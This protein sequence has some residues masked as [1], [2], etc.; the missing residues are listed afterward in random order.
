LLN[1]EESPDLA[2]SLCKKL[3]LSTNFSTSEYAIPLYQRCVRSFPNLLDDLYVIASD[4]PRQ[5]GQLMAFLKTLGSP[6]P[7]VMGQLS[8]ELKKMK[9]QMDIGMDI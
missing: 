9:L 7:E 1:Q 4:Y 8:P 2:V 5:N 6:S 3:F